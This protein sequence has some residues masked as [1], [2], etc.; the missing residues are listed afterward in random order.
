MSKTD[1]EWERWGKTAPWYGVLTEDKYR[2]KTISEKNKVDFYKSGEQ[3][4]KGV[5]KVINSIDRNFRP[6]QVVDFGC[7][8][9]RLVFAFGKIS[10]K[11]VGIDISQSMINTARKNQPKILKNIKYIVGDGSKNLP[12]HY[13]LIHSVIVFQHMNPKRGYALTDKFLKGLA[14]GGFAALHY[15]TYDDSSFTMK[16]IRLARRKSKLFNMAINVIKKRKPTTPNMQM[17]MYDLGKLMKI[18]HDN[19]LSELRISTNHPDC[20]VGC[21][22]IGQKQ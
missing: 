11:V 18:F 2:G 10:K 14:P 6:S 4:V 8:A 12:K 5:M 9:G 22:I 1:K 16:K 3:S 7:G 20:Y 15:T 17:N 13:D 21:L 19:G